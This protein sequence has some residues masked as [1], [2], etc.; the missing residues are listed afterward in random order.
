MNELTIILRNEDGT[1]T[2]LTVTPSS[3]SLQ[4][5]LRKYVFKAAKQGDKIAAE[6]LMEHFKLKIWTQE[7]I[8]EY[9]KTLEEKE[10]GHGKD[11]SSARA[12][13]RH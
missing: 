9:N 3:L 10:K 12:R 5:Q 6:W 1:E 2:E 4:P 11:N 7:E 13:E 8:D